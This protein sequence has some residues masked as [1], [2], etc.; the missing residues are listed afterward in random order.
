SRAQLQWARLYAWGPKEAGWGDRGRVRMAFVNPFSLDPVVL[1]PPARAP[2]NDGRRAGAAYARDGQP[3]APHLYVALDP[4]HGRGR[5]PLR[6]S[7]ETPLFVFEKD[8]GPMVVR[9]AAV[10]GLNGLEDAVKVGD[11]WFTIQ[12][13]GTSVRL[14]RVRGGQLDEL[15]G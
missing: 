14:L 8:W 2:C 11:A 3:G 7:S 6:S 1:T 10:L 12:R 5:A 13:V 4:S 9:G 15:E